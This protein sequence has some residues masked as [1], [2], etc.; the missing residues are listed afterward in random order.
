MICQKC[1]AEIKET[2]KF[3]N[4]CGARNNA[5]FAN[6]IEI[7]PQFVIEDRSEFQKKPAN[8]SE[9]QKQEHSTPNRDTAKVVSNATGEKVVQALASHA[10]EMENL[11][12]SMKAGESP[13]S[14]MRP[15]KEVAKPVQK[16]TT[17]NDITE[18]KSKLLA[19]LL[20][21]F[22]GI[23][24]IQWF[25][26]GKK[27]RGWIYLGIFFITGLF[28]TPLYGIYVYLCMAEGVYL[29][30]STKKGFSKYVN[31]I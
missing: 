16:K 15:S 19:G 18:R 24:G 21:F 1:G 8:S 30:F 25:Y 9:Q 20:G 13:T 14:D 2:M 10:E 17:Q 3:C 28:I 5:P 27:T 11:V 4:K 22:L 6:N 12:N 29:L 26:L 7:E 23:F 31:L